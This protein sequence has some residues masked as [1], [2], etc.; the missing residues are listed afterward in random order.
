[1]LLILNSFQDII[2]NFISGKNPGIA[3]F[4]EWWESEGHKKSISLPEQQ[5]AIRVLTIHKS[6]GLE[7][8]IVILPFISWNLDHKSFHS[9]ILWVRPGTPPF[10]KLGIVPVSYRSTL[11]ETI[12][13]EDYYDEKYS[14]YVDNVNL[15]Y[16]ALT[17][18]KNGIYGFAP[19]EPG[20]E[21]RI[22]GILKEAIDFQNAITGRRRGISL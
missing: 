10:N 14:A 11:S 20:S 9:N 19:A 8:G 3:S 15:L 2:I 12:F 7:F 1:M 17:R 4:L 16:V 18:A 6:K 22:A 13:S 5:D 21:N